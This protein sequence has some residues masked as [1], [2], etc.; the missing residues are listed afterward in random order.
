[1][2]NLRTTSSSWHIPMA[3]LSGGGVCPDLPGRQ[4]PLRPELSIA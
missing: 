1:M 4:R 3:M 2:S